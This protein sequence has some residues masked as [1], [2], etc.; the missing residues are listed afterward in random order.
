MKLSRALKKIRC[1]IDIWLEASMVESIGDD[2]IAI[3]TTTC[4]SAPR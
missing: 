2:S 4:G 3:W 1:D